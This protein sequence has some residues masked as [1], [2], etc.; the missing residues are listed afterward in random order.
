MQEAGFE[1]V[2]ACV[3]RMQNTD[4]SVVSPRLR[5]QA[6]QQPTFPA[7]LLRLIQQEFNE[8]FRQA[9]ERRQEVR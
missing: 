2:E 5:A 4:A 8:S 7:A 1:D 6:R 3:I 9:L